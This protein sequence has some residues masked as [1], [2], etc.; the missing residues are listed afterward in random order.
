MRTITYRQSLERNLLGI[1]VVLS[2]AL[3]ATAMFLTRR[4]V[5][6]LSSAMIRGASREVETE[7]ERFFSPAP[8]GLVALAESVRGGV[9]SLDE[10]ELFYTLLAP[11]L[12]SYPPACSALLADGSGREIML[13]RTADG[14]SSRET[15]VGAWGARSRMTTWRHTPADGT[16]EWRELG[17]DPRTRPWWEG[18]ISRR[19]AIG[20]TEPTL[21]GVHWTEPY[22]FFTTGDLGVSASLAFDGPDGVTMTMAI[23]VHLEQISEFCDGL[24]VTPGSMAF[25]LT[26]DMRLIGAP[27][28]E[29]IP[30]REAQRAAMLQ[31]YTAV[32][33]GFL[34]DTARAFRRNESGAVDA[35]KFRFGGEAWWAG[36]RAVPM[37]DGSQLHVAVLVPESDL[38][39]GLLHVRIGAGVIALAA[40]GLTM[41][42][43]RALAR[44]FSRPIEDLVEASDLIAK[45]DLRDQRT[46]D[47]P[48]R[49]LQRLARAQQR[50]RESLRNMLRLE[51]DL[52]IARQIQASTLP[53]TLPQPAG[54]SIAAWSEPAEETGGD[55]Y[56]VIPFSR[57]P[58]GSATIDH[59][60]PDVVLLL[61]AD[62]TGHGVGPALAVT[63]FRAMV[64][65][66][67]HVDADIAHSF[68]RINA[69]LHDDLPE[70]RFITAWI[71]SLDP[72]THTIRSASAGQGPL[73][74][75][76]HATGE[77]EE[78]HPDTP[79][80]GVL[81]H[82][83][84][85]KPRVVELGPGDAM[86]ILSDGFAEMRNASDELFGPDRMRETLASLRHEAAERMLEGLR[87]AV[88]AF[89][90]GRAADDDRT[91]VIIRRNA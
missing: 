48:I 63:Q 9:V 52:Q 77:V 14:W 18:A 32:G 35:I 85:E 13:L 84:L 47:T 74:V 49:E 88:G 10:P 40:I 19:S 2:V 15:D 66:A 83:E 42:R 58:D 70:G 1:V 7:L 28:S 61:L 38:V 75:V 50:M 22:T 44:R 41:Q 51:R 8:R 80:F 6:S 20:A 23:D 81:P 12:E 39:G 29:F 68:G 36:G 69:Q 24:R 45:L 67:I 73:L 59:D 72:R 31:P 76:R 87:D 54:Y 89:A 78:F 82:L 3:L 4:A 34:A 33:S 11:V 27:I 86:V 46:V 37:T 30:D 17:Y 79:P 26:G 5:N 43:S 57:A 55:T 71:G 53:D 21:E 64:R 91:A 16:T 56:D 65:M 62:A 90:G 25:V 60:K